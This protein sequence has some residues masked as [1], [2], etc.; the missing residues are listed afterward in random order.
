MPDDV[1]HINEEALKELFGSIYD[2]NVSNQEPTAEVPSSQAS[3]RI[4]DV[5]IWH[6]FEGKNELSN[7][8]REF[9]RKVQQAIHVSDQLTR[10]YFGP[11]RSEELQTKLRDTNA[12][13]VFFWSEQNEVFQGADP[14]SI[15]IDGDVQCLVLRS[16]KTIMSNK[17]EKFKLWNLL[18]AASFSG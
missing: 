13:F 16:L 10:A 18:K 3:A 15:Q 14:Y 17:D 5:K 11:Y 2:L 6:C 7:A 4:T 9:V 12:E 8:E 1:F